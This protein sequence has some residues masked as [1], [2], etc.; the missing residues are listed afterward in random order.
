MGIKYCIA[1]P[2][3]PSRHFFTDGKLYDAFVSYANSTDDRKFVNF[4]LKPQ[5]ENRHGY[6][7]FLDDQNILPNSGTE[8]VQLLI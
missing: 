1:F 7:L 6:K 8:L 4:I 2:S 5:L 3:F